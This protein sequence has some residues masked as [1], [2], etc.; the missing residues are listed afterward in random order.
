MG[1]LKGTVTFSRYRI[2]GPLPDGFN[3]F[4]DERIRRFSFQDNWRTADEKVAGWIS[5]ENCLDT[6]FPYAAYAQGKYLLFSLRIDRKSIPPSLLRIR[7]M[8]AER[9]HLAESG[10]KKLYREQR[11]AIRD[12][13]RLNLLAQ[14]LPVPSFY[15][16]CWSTTDRLLIFGSLSDKIGSELQEM[17]RESFTMTLIPHT[18]WHVEEK[19]PAIQETSPTPP[20]P[21]TPALA[22]PAG[23]DPLTIGREFLTWLWFKSEERNGT[24][25]NPAGGEDEII[26]LRRLVLESGEGE[27]AESII[28]QG[29]HADLKEGKEALRRGKKITTARLRVAHDQ[30]EWE[31][32]FKADRF[33]FQ[34]MK[35]PAL[36][37]EDD[38]DDREGQILERI[39]LIE[40]ATVTMDNLFH[41]FLTLHQSADWPGEQ[42]RV[43]KWISQ[44]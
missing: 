17:F 31:F 44:T 25:A 35:L 26:F 15:E 43:H 6:D 13:V 4:F 34:S 28:C 39:Y 41:S 38:D 21:D 18:P 7:V 14:T 23:V 22:L 29:L 1:F 42:E 30:E 27:Y 9:K 3:D 19:S 32:T 5:I 37:G 40:K 20:P 10:Q 24:I 12:S 2:A 16:I 33:H 36:S 8:E 11:E